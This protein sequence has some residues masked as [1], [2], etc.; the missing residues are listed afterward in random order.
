MAETAKKSPR[1]NPLFGAAIVKAVLRKRDGVTASS[2]LYEGILRDLGVDRKST[3]LNS[4]HSQISYAVFCLKKKKAP[5]ARRRAR[6]CLR[7]RA[8]RALRPRACWI[9][10][11]S[12][13]ITGRDTW[14]TSKRQPKLLP[15]RIR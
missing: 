10:P 14:I 12:D 1:K 9:E 4:S 2:E 5:R 15:P 3:R 11:C 8:R 6:C 7:R 13:G